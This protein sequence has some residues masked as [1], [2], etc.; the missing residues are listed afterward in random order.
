MNLLRSLLSIL[1][2]DI[3]FINRSRLSKLTYGGHKKISR[4]NRKTAI[5]AFSSNGL[6]PFT[7]H[8]HKLDSGTPDLFPKVTKIEM[9][10]GSQG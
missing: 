3:E 7:K 9:A 8:I 5:I 6:K 1:D 2:D 10:E 4:I